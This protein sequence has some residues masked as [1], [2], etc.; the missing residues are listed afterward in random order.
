MYGADTAR[1]INKA[2]LY[3]QHF[4]SHG[5]TNVQLYFIVGMDTALRFFHPR[6][7]SKELEDPDCKSIDDVLRPFFDNCHLIIA[8]R[9]GI[10]ILFP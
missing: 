9:G 5:Y 10:L 4:T 3:R 7:Y 1:F 6:Y 2:D 8:P